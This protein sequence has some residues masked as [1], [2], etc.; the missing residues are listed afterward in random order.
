MHACMHVCMMYE[1]VYA[2]MHASLYVDNPRGKQ[3]NTV[4]VRLG[5]K[6]VL[7]SVQI[8]SGLSANCLALV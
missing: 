7:A 4:P 1:G 3:L 2:F 6:L 5:Y 8:G